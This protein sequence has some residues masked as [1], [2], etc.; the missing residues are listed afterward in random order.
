MF[1]QL[2]RHVREGDCGYALLRSQNRVLVMLGGKPEIVLIERSQ[3]DC[4]TVRLR[5]RAYFLN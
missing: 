1:L 5:R 2:S 4:R 3:S